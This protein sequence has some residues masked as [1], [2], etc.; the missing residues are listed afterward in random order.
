MRQEDIP[1]VTEIEHISFSTSWPA[2]AYRRELKDNRLARYIVARWVDPIHPDEGASDAGDGQ[3]P[4]GESDNKPSGLKRLLSQIMTP[5]RAIGP[6]QPTSAGPKLGGY[7]GL[8]LMVDE[9]HITTI[10]VRPH[11]RGRGLGE[12]IMVALTDLATAAGADRM[13]LEVRVSNYEAQAVYRRFGFREE[14]VRRR[15]Y[16]DNNEDALIMWS[17][18]LSS[19]S[20]TERLVDIRRQVQEKMARHPLPPPALQP[21]AAS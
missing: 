19:P 13:T 17:E 21:E 16:S 7:A 1:E 18:P 14:G 8:W 5:W 15:Y 2:Q 9:A 3:P 11:L 20:F 6:A 12:L 10:A 4:S